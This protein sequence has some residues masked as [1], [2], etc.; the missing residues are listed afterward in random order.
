MT[1]DLI[2]ESIKVLMGS[3]GHDLEAIPVAFDD[4]Q[5][6]SADGAR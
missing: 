6:A 1:P 5:R 4:L 3:Q 2:G